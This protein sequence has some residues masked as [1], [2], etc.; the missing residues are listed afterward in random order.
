MNRIK[1]GKGVLTVCTLLSA[2]GQILSV[3][4]YGTSLVRKYRK[5]KK[6]AGF[7]ST[8]ESSTTTEE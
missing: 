7:A 3:V 6:V 1:I 2:V 5:P 4:E 8:T